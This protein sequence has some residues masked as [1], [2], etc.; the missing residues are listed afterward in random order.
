MADVDLQD[1]LELLTSCVRRVQKL[2]AI[3][4][5]RSIVQSELDILDA[6]WNQLRKNLRGD[7]HG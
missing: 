1:E 3:R 6:R 7:D 5:P 2:K 4:A